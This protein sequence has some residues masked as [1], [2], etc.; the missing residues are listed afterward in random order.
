MN[1]YY[2][3][4]ENIEYYCQNNVKGLCNIHLCSECYK[5]FTKNKCYICDGYIMPLNTTIDYEEYD[6]DDVIVCC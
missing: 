1:C 2:C 3:D 6:E 4:T 5:C